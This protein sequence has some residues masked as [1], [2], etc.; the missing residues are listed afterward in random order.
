MMKYS[1]PTVT[2][3]KDYYNQDSAIY[4]AVY[5]RIYRSPVKV[6]LKQLLYG[7]EQ[8]GY[9]EPSISVS[10][11]DLSRKEKVQLYTKNSDGTVTYT[12]GHPL[13]QYNDKDNVTWVEIDWY[14]QEALDGETFNIG[15][16][17]KISKR[18]TGNINYTKSWILAT[19][20]KGNS[21]M[22]QAQLYDPYFYTVNNA[23]VTGY[24]NAAVPYMVFYDPKSYHT[25]LDATEFQAADRSGNIFVP[26]TDTV[27]ENFYATF[28]IYR[29]KTPQEVMSTQ[30]TTKVDIPPYHRIYN[31]EAEEE[32]DATGTYTGNNVLHWTIKNPRL[33][34]LVDGDYFEIQRALKEDFSD[35]QQLGIQR[36]MRDSI[37]Y[38]TFQDNSR[39][40]WTGNAAV[41]T[42]TV[43]AQWKTT[44]K[45]YYIYDMLKVKFFA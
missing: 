11:F 42:D 18:M 8:D 43:D 19:D 21:N 6:H 9:G 34:D 27:Q 15:T 14:P 36:M 25:S 39:E 7:M 20:I 28:Q 4:N 22:I 33:V 3:A 16:E 37:G 45:H 2:K 31:F 17:V 44:L 38:Y 29:M 23:G 1:S 41:R 5:D 32:K 10:G 13:F 35:A 30:M 26:T 12:L 24:G 40:I